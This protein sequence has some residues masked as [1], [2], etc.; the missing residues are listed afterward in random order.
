MTFIEAPTTFYLGRKFDLE[1][2]RMIDEVVYYDS[3]DLTTHAVVVGMTGSG[4]TGLCITL[5]EEAVMDNIPAIIID[6]KGDITNLML[7]FP[8]L[9]PQEFRPWI[10]EDDARRAG[11]SEDEFAQDIAQ[12][13]QEGLA[14]WGIGPQRIHALKNQAQFSIF[15]PGSDAGLPISILDALQPPREGW[16]GREEQHRERISGIVTA[17]M[18]LIGK[19]VNTKDREHVL[20]A[21]IIE[22]A[23]QQNLPLTISDII[24]QIQQPPFKTLGVFDVNTFFPEKDRF[25]VAIDL[26]SIIASP[27]FNTW[28]Q[29]EPLDIHS[30]MYTP[31]GRPRV[32]VFYIA[33]L[34]EAQRSFIITLILEGMLAWMRT[35]GGTSSLRSILYFDEVFGHFPP[36]PKNPPTK[37]PLLRLLKQARAFGIGLIL[38]TQNP[39]D[40]DY[41]GLSNAGTWF[42][43]KLQTENDKKKVLDGLAT[44]SQAESAI[45]MAEMDVLLSTLSPRTFVLNNVHDSASASVMHTRWA[46][47]YLRGPLT[48][49]QVSQLMAPQKQNGAVV[50]TGMY[51]SQPQAPV[52]PPAPP[53]YS[54]PVVPPPPATN[55]Q[56]VPQ[57]QFQNQPP[58]LPGQPPPNYGQ[59]Q[60][61]GAPPSSAPPPPPSLPEI[62]PPLSLP[63]APSAFN[64][65]GF[66]ANTPPPLP[67]APPSQSPY[68]GGYG[69]PGMTPSMPPPAQGTGGIPVPPQLPPSAQPTHGS[70]AQNTGSYG[71][72]GDGLPSGYSMVT[73]SLSS[74][75]TQYFLPVNVPLQQA[76]AYWEQ[77]FNQR[78]ANAMQHLILYQPFLM[79]QCEVRYLNRKMAINTIEHYAYHVFDVQRSG[80]LHWEEHIAPSLSSRTLESDPMSGAGF[81]EL[82][83]GLTDRKRMTGLEKEVIDVIYKTASITLPVHEELKI[84]SSP[85]QPLS[86]F[87]ARVNGAARELRD[88][89]IDKVTEKF[90]RDFDRYEEKYKREARELDADEAALDGLGKES[91]ATMGE[92]ALSLLRG[93]TTYTLSRVSRV[94]R[95]QEQA[96]KDV[97]ESEQVLSEITGQMDELQQR[98]EIE[99]GRIN[100]KWARIASNVTD[101]RVTPY[102]KDIHTELFGIGWLPAYYVVLAGRGEMLPAWH[103]QV[104][105]PMQQQQ[106]APPQAR[107]N[108]GYGQ[109]PPPPQPPYNQGYGAPPQQQGYGQPQPY[110][111]GYGQQPPPQQPYNQGYGAP[112]QQQ[113]YGQAPP[114]NQGYGQQ[115]PPPQQPPQPP[116]GQGYGQQPQYGSGDFYDQQGYNYPNEGAPDDS[117][118]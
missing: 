51:R 64:P 21:N 61:I 31:D 78:A 74:T 90:E 108:Q 47:S 105:S 75:V 79:V 103:G 26:N 68:G 44:A 5:L 40:L 104:V 34:N 85:G 84:Y 48:R 76:L 114:Y 81:G 9:S 98:F 3:R 29:G 52:Q 53:A 87:R 101:V 63:E 77:Q 56:G 106:M 66:Q 12:R 115:P 113:G 1:N 99:I 83:T 60:G 96:K 54:Q 95:Y 35:L 59:P 8:N 46:M 24:V 7:T 73:P 117:Y 57:G 42:I 86:D 17:L 37:D 45:D 93:R 2:Q 107:Y 70:P 110:N 55:F 58:S 71:A 6:P 100:D 22:Y 32:S 92:A 28:L 18:A 27:S 43:G 116:Q 36:Y 82:P 65:A 16:V 13:W 69:D 109:Q 49:T 14:S 97:S 89:E 67:I 15:T 112:P 39:G 41:K 91:W 94:R 4:K 38:A 50:Q 30:L 118:Y 19:K 102:K 33:H 88:A 25:K 23:W 20:I 10:N 72:Q 62:A 80:L 11:L 111:Q